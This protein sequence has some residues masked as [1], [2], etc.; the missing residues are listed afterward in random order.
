[1]ISNNQ[2][3]NVSNSNN[4]QVKCAL[5]LNISCENNSHHFTLQMVVMVACLIHSENVLVCKDLRNL[6]PSWFSWLWTCASSWCGAASPFGSR[7]SGPSPSPPPKLCCQRD[8]SLS[9][10]LSGMCPYGFPW[11]VPDGLP[12]VAQEEVLFLGEGWSFCDHSTVPMVVY[13]AQTQRPCIRPTP[14]SRLSGQ[15][16]QC[17][18]CDSWRH[19]LKSTI[20]YL[21]QFSELILNVF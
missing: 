11:V 5:R 1:M 7:T 19:L 21:L 4:E 18:Q 16:P 14:Y 9:L 15:H 12:Q 10:S 13:Q 6:R 2:K 17:Q 8:S 20:P 3:K